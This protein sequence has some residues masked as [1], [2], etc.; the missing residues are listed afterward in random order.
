MDKQTV[1]TTDFGFPGK[2]KMQKSEK[3]EKTKH[4]Y[5]VYAEQ[6]FDN[7]EQKTSEAKLM[8]SEALIAALMFQELFELPKSRR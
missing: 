3:E 8:S 5:L 7:A 4:T 1:K 2:R 6:A